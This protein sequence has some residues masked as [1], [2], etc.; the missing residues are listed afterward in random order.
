MN[1]F[2]AID[3]NIF[4]YSLNTDS[5]DHKSAQTFLLH[6]STYFITPQN[7]L[8]I[9]NVITD[10]RKFPSP[11]T[12]P[13]AQLTLESIAEHD[14]CE[15][16]TPDE[17]TWETALKLAIKYGIKGQQKIYDCYLAATLLENHIETLYTANT[18]DFKVF[19]FI[20]SHNPLL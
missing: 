4:I 20:H 1:K 17:N 10:S 12:P 19:P 16:I 8:E 7:I 6:Q 13:K 11:F 15:L 5:R 3:S 14:S 2:G 9:Y 18:E